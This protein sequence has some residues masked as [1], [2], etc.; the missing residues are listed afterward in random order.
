MISSCPLPDASLDSSPNLAQNPIPTPNPRHSP[1]LS[2]NQNK[3]Q[4]YSQVVLQATGQSKK[5][6]KIC[7]MPPAPNKEPDYSLPFDTIAS[8]VM[9]D[10]LKFNQG[11]CGEGGADPLYDSIDEMKIRNIF[12]SEAESHEPSYGKMEHIYDDPEGCAAAAEEQESDPVTRVYDD[13]EEMKGDAWKIMGTAVDPGGHEYPYNACEDDY[14]VPK[15]TKRAFPLQNSAEEDD[16][17]EGLEEQPNEE[18]EQQSD[19]PYN[20]VMVKMAWKT[21]SVCRF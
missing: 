8:N 4:M 9:S 3:D 17:T 2:S 18:G 16:Q 19:S 11:P 1:K 14:A 12:R 7:G 21:K 10:I 20:N 5:K 6:E 15:R 13:P